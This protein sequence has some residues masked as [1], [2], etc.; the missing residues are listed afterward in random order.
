MGWLDGDWTPNAVQVRSTLRQFVRDWAK[1][2]QAERAAS[3][4]PLISALLKH[5]PP[6]GA[7]EWLK[8]YSLA[9]KRRVFITKKVPWALVEV[10][11]WCELLDEHPLGWRKWLVGMN[12]LDMFFA[13]NPIFDLYF[14]RKTTLQN[15]A[16][17]PIKTRGPIWVLG[18]YI[19]YVYIYIIPSLVT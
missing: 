9:L 13:W 1:E 15:K 10:F 11:F 6:K 12:L 19:I 18:V 7:L 4:S 2:G 3:Y 17:L 16:E 8:F 5:L 14:W